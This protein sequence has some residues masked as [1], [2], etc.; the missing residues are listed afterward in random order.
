[1][2]PP[3]RLPGS[4]WSQNKK[5]AATGRISGQAENTNHVC[6]RVEP[7]KRMGKLN[8]GA[9][10][11]GEGASVAACCRPLPVILLR[12]SSVC[13]VKQCP[14]IAVTLAGGLRHR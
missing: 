5:V 12:A 4:K 14:D 9:T 7:R 10:K 8:N 1:L 13:A 6:W 2:W 11:S 3:L